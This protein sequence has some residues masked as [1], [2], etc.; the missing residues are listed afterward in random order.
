M[1]FA[2]VLFCPPGLRAFKH[3]TPSSLVSGLSQR[4]PECQ[5]SEATW[6]LPQCRRILSGK[7]KAGMRLPAHVHLVPQPG[8]RAGIP[9]LPRH[10]PLTLVHRWVR[11]VST[12]PHLP[13]GPALAPIHSLGCPETW[14]RSH[15]WPRP[16]LDSPGATP[17]SSP[18]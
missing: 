3:W 9:D 13:A 1:Y 17:L 15:C 14:L 18:L 12:F 5:V 11:V 4:G 10:L 8:S 2:M 7:R 16:R 6:H